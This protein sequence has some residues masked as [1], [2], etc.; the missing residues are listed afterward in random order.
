MC[1]KDNR[2]RTL[3]N[4]HKKGKKN[5]GEKEKQEGKKYNQFLSVKGDP[6]TTR[7]NRTPISTGNRMN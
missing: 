3:N 1:L 6:N 4:N 2:L 7:K 5:V